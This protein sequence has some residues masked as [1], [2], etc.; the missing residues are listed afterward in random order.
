MQT[1]LAVGLGGAFGAIARYLLVSRIGHA[2]GPGGVAGIPVG[3]VTVN[4]LGSVVM[5]L[6]TEY[7]ALKWSPS[8]EMRAFLTVGALGGF[9]T[10]STFALEAGVL[11]QRDAVAQA[12]I[13][14]GGS[15]ML[16]ILGLFAGLSIMR[17]LLT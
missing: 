17:W 6:V 2:V 9:T 3:V 12:V 7:L 16:S 13:Y 11:L 1:L 8:A 4:L 15:V 14:I 5:G 10:F